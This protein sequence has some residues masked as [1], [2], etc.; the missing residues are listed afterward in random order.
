MNMVSDS[1]LQLISSS[2]GGVSKKNIHNYMRRLIKGFLFPAMYLYE[3]R[4]SSETST[5]T[6]YFKRLNVETD[7]RIQ[8]SFFSFY[9]IKKYIT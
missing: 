5:E 8:L 9:G 4:F 3:A 2:F 1:T 7:I 6:T